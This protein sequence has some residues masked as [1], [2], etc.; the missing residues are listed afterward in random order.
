MCFPWPGIFNAPNRCDKWDWSCGCGCFVRLERRIWIWLGGFIRIRLRGSTRWYG[1][2]RIAVEYGLNLTS[3]V[4]AGALCSPSILCNFCFGKSQSNLHIRIWVDCTNDTHRRR[5][6]RMSLMMSLQNQRPIYEKF[7]VN[8]FSFRRIRA[9]LQV[10]FIIWLD[11]CV[12]II[13]L[14][15]TVL[16]VWRS[17]LSANEASR[18]N[19]PYFTIWLTGMDLK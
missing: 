11:F 16:F 1:I 2:D 8:H 14:S 15:S 3:P 19:S 4:F 13:A 7:S 6:S 5:L 9:Y 10:E 18:L 17:R 12:N